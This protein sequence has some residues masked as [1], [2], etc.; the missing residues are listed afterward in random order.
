MFK[1]RHPP[2][3]RVSIAEFKR[4]VIQIVRI[5][6]EY[7]MLTFN[8]SFYGAIIDDEM[9]FLHHFE[10]K[11]NLFTYTRRHAHMLSIP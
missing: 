1:I 3:K 11:R 4:P 2:M 5:M 10:A 6:D 7:A 8:K 9:Q